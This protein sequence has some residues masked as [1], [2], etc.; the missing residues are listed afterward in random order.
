[1]IPFR[2]DIGLRLLCICGGW[3]FSFF[4]PFYTYALVIDRTAC[5]DIIHLHV[6]YSNSLLLEVTILL[7]MIDMSRRPKY[8]GSPFRYADVTLAG[9]S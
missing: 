9:N 6:V 3:C 2:F 1:M 5:I 8:T 4:F 7:S